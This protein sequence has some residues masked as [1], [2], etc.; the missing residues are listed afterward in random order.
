M[1]AYELRHNGD[2]SGS[3][4][5][6]W[7]C[8]CCC[9]N[10]G[11]SWSRA[12]SSRSICGARRS[13]PMSMPASTPRSS[14][15]ARSW[16]T[17][18]SHHTSWRP[19]RERLSV[20]CAGRGRRMPGPHGIDQARSTGSIRASAGL[21]SPQPARGTHLLRGTRHGASR[22]ASSAHVVA[23]GVADGR[24]R[25]WEDAVGGA[26]GP[27]SHRAIPSRCVAGRS[28]A[29]H[30]SR[31]RGPDDRHRAEFPRKPRALGARRTGRHVAR[32]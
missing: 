18:P 29:A 21:A 1:R 27:R 8:C 7:T 19:C 6:R 11:R 10:A 28:G 16:A 15:F 4:G 5:S 30:S 14:G 2:R 9:S 12:S 25:R 20:H 13:S 31:S 17:R 32:S 24:R 23:A 3:R 26:A 22:T